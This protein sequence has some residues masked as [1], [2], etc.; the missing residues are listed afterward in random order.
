MWKYLRLVAVCG[1]AGAGA[2]QAEEALLPLCPQA[3]R[4]FAADPLLRK[5][6]AAAYPRIRRQRTRDHRAADPCLY[7]Y[8]AILYDRVV[9]LITLKQVPGEGCHG[10]PA[11]LSADFLNAR[12]KRLVRVG[13]H[14]EFGQSGTFAGNI[15]L[16]PIR[17]GGSDGIVIEGSGTFQ[18]V[19]ASVLDVFV[20]R[21]GRALSIGPAAGIP[22][23]Y[24][25]C[26][27]RGEGEPCGN[28][29]ARWTADP[30][31]RLLVTY[32]GKR[33]NKRRVQATVIYE[34]R[35]DALIVVSGTRTAAEMNASRP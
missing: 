23:G 15:S 14:D 26:G 13:R 25:T 18:G 2:A 28:V 7:P 30:G 24:N 4:A 3:S 11:L 17:F 9:V 19:G 16:T 31:G 21:N 20:F 27:A 29:K 1:L 33:A 12:R 34:R 6:V 32:S 8:Q 5:A 10:C 22:A 35:G